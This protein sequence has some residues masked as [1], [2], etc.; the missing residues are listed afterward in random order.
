MNLYENTI[1]QFSDEYD[2]C[3]KNQ[4]RDAWMAICFLLGV[5][6]GSC[7]TFYF[8]GWIKKDDFVLLPH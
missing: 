1:K 6:F 4:I 3:K 7:L 2:R 5:A 8:I